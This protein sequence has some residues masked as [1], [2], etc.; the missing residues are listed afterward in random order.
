ML[1]VISF[2]GVKDSEF[3][4]MAVNKLRYPNIT[5]FMSEASYTGGVRSVFVSNT[6]PIH[7]S[8]STCSL[9]KEHGIYSNILKH[10][11]TGYAHWMQHSYLIKKKTIFE[12]CR[13][14]GLKVGA[15]SWPV[16][17]GAKIKYN[18][19]ELHIKEGQNRLWHQMKSGSLFFQLE[20]FLRHRKKLDG[21]KQPKLD[22]FFTAVAIDLIKNKQPDLVLVHLLAYD[23]F[24]HMVGLDHPV[25]D[26]GRASLDESL[27]KILKAA[28]DD[29]TFL[30]FSDHGHLNVEKTVNLKELFGEHLF[31]Q[32]GGCAFFRVPVDNLQNQPWFERML[33]VDEM[34]TCRYAPLAVM[35]IAAKPGFFFGEKNY[36]GNHGYPVD[37]E[38]YQVFY[39]FKGGK[40]T[41]PEQIFGDIRD[42]GNIICSE[43]K[44]KGVGTHA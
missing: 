8:V 19:P 26:I 37:Y 22:N 6:Y 33:T 7:T 28:P 34:D 17:C 23:T 44:L 15:I 5:R 42:V 36:K 32:C 10:D 43:L 4:A 18:L 3:E 1:I 25:L 30:V 11:D 39:A 38:N 16:T 13:E 35:G 29:A 9:P 41:L 14:K 40:Q 27:G 2:D 31:E 20:A 12:A 21:L 24:C